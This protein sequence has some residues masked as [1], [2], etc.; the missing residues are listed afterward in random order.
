MVRPRCAVLAAAVF[1]AGCGTSGVGLDDAEPTVTLFP[2]DDAIET[3]D[4]YGST[5]VTPDTTEAAVVR[6]PIPA[7][8]RDALG[9]VFRAGVALPVTMVDD[10]GWTAIRPCGEVL[11][12]TSPAPQTF[13]VMVDPG[14]DAG[15]DP[16]SVAAADLIAQA[17]AAELDG[18]EVS[19][20]L[21][22][23]GTADVAVTDR[24]AA[25]DASGARVLVSI[26]VG[27]DPREGFEV[28]HRAGDT[29]SHRLA[30][31]VLDAALAELR[32]VDLDFGGDPSVAG[33]VNQR[34][35]DYYAVLRTDD[36]LVGVVVRLPASAAQLDVVEEVGAS[37]GRSMAAGIYDF[38]TT[39]SS[40][41][42]GA[43]TETVRTAPIASGTAECVDP[44]EPD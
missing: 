28:V 19:S 1:I 29:E 40:A 2:D 30:G 26:V 9:V 35:S 18:V 7:P 5:S 37:L 22:R 16:D 6:A 10:S 41:R 27:D 34:G 4:D 23:R 8:R 31:L 33:V 44:T 3:V 36:D 12:A 14:G 25:V 13:V 24:L 39:D 11:V 21:T 43:P 42:V 38:V 17:L 20:S 15:S 32:G